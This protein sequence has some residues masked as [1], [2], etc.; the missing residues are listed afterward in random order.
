MVQLLKRLFLFYYEGFRG[1]KIGKKLWL[2]IAIKLF[3]LL[4][5]VK[6]LFFPDFL[7]THFKSDAQRSDYIFEQLTHPKE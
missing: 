1:M 2:L 5:V 7:K 4:V 3:L 6:W